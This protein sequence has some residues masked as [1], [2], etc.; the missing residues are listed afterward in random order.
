LVTDITK[1]PN[2]TPSSKGSLNSTYKTA[3]MASKVSS[4]YE[5]ETHSD[6]T[7][8]ERAHRRHH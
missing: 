5:E 6:T 7:S 3:V 2:L 1:A 4:E 8:G